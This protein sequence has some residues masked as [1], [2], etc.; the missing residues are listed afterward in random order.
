MRIQNK[1]YIPIICNKKNNKSLHILVKIIFPKINSFDQTEIVLQ[2]LVDIDCSF[3]S[4][5]KSVV[6]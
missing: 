2:A 3:T 4:I 1:D 5:C 6:P